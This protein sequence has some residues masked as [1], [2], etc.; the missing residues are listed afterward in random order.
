MSYNFPY[1]ES[2]TNNSTESFLSLEDTCHNKTVSNIFNNQ[3]LP[4]PSS[5][6]ETRS[7]LEILGSLSPTDAKELVELLNGQRQ[8]EV[9]NSNEVPKRT[10]RKNVTLP[11]WN[12]KSEDFEFYIGRLETRIQRELDSFMEPSAICL[13]MIDTLPEKKQSRVAYW[14]E[15]SKAREEFDWRELIRVFRKE[16]ENKDARQAASEILTRM[17]Q[18]KNQLFVDFLRDF[19][20][21]LALSGGNE[22]F[23]PLGKTQ[24]LKASLNSRLRRSLIGVKLPSPGNYKEWVAEVKEVAAELESAPGYRPKNATETSTKIGAPKGGNV[25]SEENADPR[26]DSE[27]DTIMGGT[28][29]LLAA[30]RDLVKDRDVL[31]ANIGKEKGSKKSNSGKSSSSNEKS[32]KPRAPWR[33]AKEFQQLREK[34]LCTRCT[35]KGHVS[36]KCPT[37]MPARR[38]KPMISA[39]EQS[40]E[41][42]E[43]D[44][45]DSNSISDSGNEDS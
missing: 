17:V 18:G 4:N 41:D 29:A 45:E 2:D 1:S 23:T 37:H 32:T 5:I 35:K 8:I 34:G 12:G 33:S 22:A 39:V 11:K 26:I 30:I 15:E 16:F 42:S 44:I 27:G 19:E 9:P 28:N 10:F 14:F 38:D 13:D 36:W 31:L 24:Q 21:R 40:S 7:A 43:S 3:S 6:M 20:Y 25:I